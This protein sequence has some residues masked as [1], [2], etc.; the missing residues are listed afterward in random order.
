[1]KFLLVAFMVLSM[2]SIS[3]ATFRMEGS[4]VKSEC[5]I[6]GKMITSWEKDTYNFTGPFMP[7]GSYSGVGLCITHCDDGIC[8]TSPAQTIQSPTIKVC[9]ECYGK[10]SAIFEKMFDNKLKQV[11]DDNK[12]QRIINQQFN[13]KMAR[14]ELEKKRKELDEQIKG[15]K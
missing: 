8:H 11:Q 14:K 13:K 15:L 1:M 2:V 5:Q 10:Y 6:C 9:K 3:E 4:C 12:D 7:S